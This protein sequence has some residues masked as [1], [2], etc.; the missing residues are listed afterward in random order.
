MENDDVVHAG[1]QELA[2]VNDELRKEV[3]ILFTDEE[4]KKRFIEVLTKSVEESYA[5]MDTLGMLLEFPNMMQDAEF[6]MDMQESMAKHK[7]V[8]AEIIKKMRALS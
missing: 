5:I 6:R 2:C 8:L 7:L 4:R 3:D 1:D